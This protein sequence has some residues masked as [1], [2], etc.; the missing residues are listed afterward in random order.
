MTI[1]RCL[2]FFVLLFFASCSIATSVVE[3]PT[4]Q[5]ALKKFEEDDFKGSHRLFKRLQERYP[6]E[7]ILLNNL[8]VVAT[9]MNQLD[10]AT[11]LLELAITTNPN[12]AVSYANLRT[13]YAHRA[14]QQYK[15]TLALDSL[16]LTAPQLELI[17]LA[18]PEKQPE[19]SPQEIVFADKTI[20]GSLVE[21][22]LPDSPTPDQK[23]EIVVAIQQWA[24][25]WS[26][27][28]L[29]AYFDSYV[30]TYQPRGG[31][32]EQWRQ[33]REQRISSPE[34]IE[35]RISNLAVET[36]DSHNVIATLN[37]HYKSNLLT[38]TVI[39][40]LGLHK[41]AEGWKIKAERVT[42]RN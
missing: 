36:K 42:R 6:D 39:K 28:D 11:Q 22:Q 18:T 25:A 31:T 37:Q 12:I 27:Q 23:E 14:S 15:E 16:D 17:G 40:T 38:S 8:A 4:Y 7:P 3:D 5:E 9:K 30:K 26:R 20:E 41:T 2:L 1:T 24:T 19:P 33:Q 21:E 32:H 29:Q 13:L 34:Y 10:L 35:V